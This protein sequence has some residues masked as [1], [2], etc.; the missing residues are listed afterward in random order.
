MPAKVDYTGVIKTMSNGQSARVIDYKNST[1]MTIE[2]EDGTIVYNVRKVHFDKGKVSNPNF[3]KLEG[4]VGEKNIMSNGVEA[5]II[6]YISATNITVR[7]KTG[8]I[9][10][11]RRYCHFQ[12]GRI[13]PVSSDYSGHKESCVG[14]SRLMKCGMRATCIEY[15][16]ASNITVQFDDGAIVRNKSKIAFYDGAILHPNIEKSYYCNKADEYLNTRKRMNCGEYCTIIKYN[17]VDDITVRFDDGE[18]IEHR[19]MNQFKLGAID[20]SR[21]K[22]NFRSLPQMIV[23][24]Y[25]KYYF[26][27]A[28]M[29]F[30]PNWLKNKHTGMNFELDIYIPEIKTALEYDGYNTIHSEENKTTKTKYQM[31]SESNMI[32]KMIVIY[33]HGC[34]KHNVNCNNKEYFL[35]NQYDYENYMLYIKD[36]LNITRDLLVDLGISDEKTSVVG[37]E[38]LIDGYN[39]SNKYSYNELKLNVIDKIVKL[40]NK[41]RK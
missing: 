7:F 19:T 25:V 6:D 26:N 15:D 5:E 8:E 18:I 1:N 12:S 21:A 29:N 9:V 35:G 32:D 36:V 40:E 30:R 27:S 33:E 24:L 41:K 20:S 39:K 23:Y 38:Y 3:N 22:L 37:L 17:T 16:T 34:V 10:Y 4:R 13:S 28:L 31:I 14:E 2:F 11:G